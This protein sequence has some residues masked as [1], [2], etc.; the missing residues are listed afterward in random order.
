LTVIPNPVSAQSAARQGLAVN[1]GWCSKRVVGF[2]GF[3][4]PEVHIFCVKQPGSHQ[5]EMKK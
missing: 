5:P 3:I 1:R 2:N 4:T